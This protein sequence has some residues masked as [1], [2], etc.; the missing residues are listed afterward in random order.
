MAY[1]NQPNNEYETTNDGRQHGLKE[2]PGHAP[3]Y[4]ELLPDND[5]DTKGKTGHVSDQIK[6]GMTGGSI[7]QPMDNDQYGQITTDH[8]YQHLQREVHNYAVLKPRNKM[9]TDGYQQQDHVGTNV[10]TGNEADN[11]IVRQQKARSEEG[12]Q[13]SKICPPPTWFRW[14][15]GIIGLF[16]LGAI[17]T[18][19]VVFLSGKY[20]HLFD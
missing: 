1:L 16:L 18:I 11:N 12:K 5:C 6:Q 10:T 4:L 3:D 15:L 17:V 2:Q 8:D 7:E 9:G 14:L 13:G 19:L 20:S